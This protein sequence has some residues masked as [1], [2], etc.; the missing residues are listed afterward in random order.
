LSSFSPADTV[1]KSGG[2]FTG[3]VIVDTNSKVK[4]KGA[5]MQSST[6]QA[7]ALGV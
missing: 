5:F 3:D 1:P 2:T 4:Q 6:H 7:L